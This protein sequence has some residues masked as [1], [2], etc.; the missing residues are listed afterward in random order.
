MDKELWSLPK[1]KQDEK[2]KQMALLYC[3]GVGTGVSA[4]LYKAGAELIFFS[5]AAKLGAV[6]YGVLSTGVVEARQAVALV[7]S[8]YNEIC[9]QAVADGWSWFRQTRV[10]NEA[11]RTMGESREQFIFALNEAMI[12]LRESIIGAL[13]TA[14]TIYLTPAGTTAVYETVQGQTSYELTKMVLTSIYTLQDK[15]VCALAKVLELMFTTCGMV[16]A[17]AI[18]MIFGNSLKIKF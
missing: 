5:L 6:I 2:I 12:N 8:Q 3:E 10:T 1:H 17:E 4:F 18:R 9:G 13:R 14:L 11:C 16:S 15:I 7:D